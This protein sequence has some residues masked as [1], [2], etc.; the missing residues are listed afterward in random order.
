VECYINLDYSVITKHWILNMNG[1]EHVKWEYTYYYYS[2]FEFAYILSYIKFFLFLGT[3]SDYY[4]QD[5]K[6]EKLTKEIWRKQCIIVASART[7]K[8]LTVSVE[9][10]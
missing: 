3:L 10:M 9:I 8:M 5:W 6:C 1:A 2:L 7:W 4:S